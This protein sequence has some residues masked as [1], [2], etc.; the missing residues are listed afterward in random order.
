MIKK[1]G[2]G[3]IVTSEKGKKLSKVVSKSK[4]KKRLAQVEYFKHISG[5]G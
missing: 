1:S 2:K 3:Y 5:K 4:A